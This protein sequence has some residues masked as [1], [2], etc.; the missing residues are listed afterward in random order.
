MVRG[1]VGKRGE[2][3]GRVRGRKG[4]GERGER[5]WREVNIITVN[6][7]LINDCSD[8]PAPRTKVILYMNTGKPFCIMSHNAR[9]ILF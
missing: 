5:R 8:K 2:G 1:R 7:V 3:G 6:K 9:S 4:E